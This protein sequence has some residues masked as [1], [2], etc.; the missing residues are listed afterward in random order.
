MRLR[1]W[2]P[3]VSFRKKL[4]E[5]YEFISGIGIFIEEPDVPRKRRDAEDADL[6]LLAVVIV[7]ERQRT[8]RGGIDR[9]GDA[10]RRRVVP[11]SGRQPHDGAPPGFGDQRRDI[12][13]AEEIESP[14]GIV[15]DIAARGVHLRHGHLAAAVVDF[16][17]DHAVGE[18]LGVGQREVVA[19]PL[20]DIAATAFV[21]A[22]RDFEIHTVTGHR[23]E[24][25]G[26]FFEYLRG[27][28]GCPALRHSAAQHHHE[29]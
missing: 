4:P 17:A 18:N 5:V 8:H 19:P 2:R 7:G 23:A 25:R 13:A 11:G 22:R 1:T 9:H 14:D 6:H 26:E 16:V 12:L 27:A 28:P 15:Q 3:G 29:K 21:I 24:P 20:D 10:A